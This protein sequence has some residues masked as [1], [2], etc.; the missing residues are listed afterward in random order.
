MKIKKPNI[1]VNKNIFNQQ[2]III[3][4]IVIAILVGIYLWGR[5]K[6]KED[7]PDFEVP[8]DPGAGADA[9]L[10]VDANF[11]QTMT[12]NLYE[13]LKGWSFLE[14]YTIA[15]WQDYATAS[16]TNFV[17]VYNEFNDR[18]YADLGNTLIAEIRSERNALRFTIGMTETKTSMSQILNKAERLNLL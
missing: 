18:Y 3:A 1:K 7:F 17:A 12:L 10:Y 13:D 4:I 6:G 15:T 11:V 2:N 14:T 8:T 16:D 5:N 9:I